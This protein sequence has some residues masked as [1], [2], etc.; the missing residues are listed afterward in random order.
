MVDAKS[1]AGIVEAADLSRKT[2]NQACVGFHQVRKDLPK[3]D[4][5]GRENW[6][7]MYKAGDFSDRTWS[8]LLA[9]QRHRRE[10]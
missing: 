8:H 4:G 5:L 1:D 9:G 6:E 7:A 3:R 2:V 10:K